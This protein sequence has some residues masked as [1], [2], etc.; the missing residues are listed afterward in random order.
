[1][2]FPQGPHYTESILSVNTNGLHALGKKQATR[3][4]LAEINT[5]FSTVFDTNFKELLVKHDHKV[6]EKPS[7]AEKKRTSIDLQE[8]TR[9]RE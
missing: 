7:A 9:S 4:A 5:S 2:A 1:M 8:G 6:Q 3:Q